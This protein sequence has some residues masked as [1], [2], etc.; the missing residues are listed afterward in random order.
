MNPIAS[1]GRRGAAAALLL[2]AWAVSLAI[3]YLWPAGGSGIRAVLD[4]SLPDLALT[5]EPVRR[6]GSLAAAVA[7]FLG[8]WGYGSA[9]VGLGRR[10]GF[11]PDRGDPLEELLLALGAGVA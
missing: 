2:A 5:R 9:L 3:A 7:V 10:R 1:P 4:G 8:A 6:L 11:A